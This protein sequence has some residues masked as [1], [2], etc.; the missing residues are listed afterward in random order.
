[1][2]YTRDV[3]ELQVETGIY[4]KFFCRSFK[5]G[6]GGNESKRRFSTAEQ[7][8][9]SSVDLT[10]AFQSG[11]VF[12][13]SNNYTLPPQN[14]DNFILSDSR[15][16]SYRS[17]RVCL[18][19]SIRVRLIADI[20]VSMCVLTNTFLRTWSRGLPDSKHVFSYSRNLLYF[21]EHKGSLPHLQQLATC[22][23]PESDRST[24]CSPFHF[25]NI[26]FNIILSSTPGSF[27]FTPSLTFPH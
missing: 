1:L 12:T 14:E 25:Y 16:L 8:I 27:K 5:N 6:T 13:C 18:F 23:Y 3:F 11:R 22:P 10:Q 20:F 21:V 4:V 9:C 24:P 17:V 2:S 26:H 7:R 19:V 15:G